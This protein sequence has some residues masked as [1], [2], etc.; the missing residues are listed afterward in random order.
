MNNFLKIENVDKIFNQGTDIEVSALKGIELVFEQGEFVVLSG[1]SGSGKTTLLNIIGGLDAPAKGEITIDGINM[2]KLSE[3]ELS[4]QRRDHIGFV[5]QSY[6]LVP[7]LSA[8]ENIEYIMKLQGKTQEECDKRVNEIADK[9]GIKE[10][11][12]KLP[13]HLSGGQQ[14]RVAVA[15]A[16][17]GKPKLIL[18]DEPTANLDSNNA[19]ELMDMM[20]KLNADEGITIIFSSHDPMVIAKA[21]RLITLKDGKVIKN[22][23]VS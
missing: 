16:V 7:V 20:E 1:P 19:N 11:L 12:N 10:L 6:N 3:T 22:E 2:T 21:K 9:L 23:I 5:F 13:S 15:R 14:Q 4:D 18:A 17:A 8:R